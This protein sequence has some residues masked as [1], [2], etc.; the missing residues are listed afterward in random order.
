MSDFNEIINS[1]T[2]TLVDFHALWCGPCKALTPI[3]EN[4]AKELG[5]TA[6]IL[7]IDIDKN[8]DTA[9]NYGVRSVPT[10][11]LFKE[12]KEVWR[13]TGVVQKNIIVESVQKVI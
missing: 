8:M 5:N 3:L 11:I 13:Q 12:G 2:P 9:R 7:K 6:K 10:M 1:E 4:V